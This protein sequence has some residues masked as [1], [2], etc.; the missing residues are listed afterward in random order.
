[1]FSFD[2]FFFFFF[3]RNVHFLHV[4]QIPILFQL[5]RQT[6][7]YERVQE[8]IILWRSDRW[9]IIE[10]MTS[11]TSYCTGGSDLFDG[12]V[13]LRSHENRERII[14]KEFIV[15]FESWLE[16]LNGPIWSEIVPSN[17]NLL[18]LPQTGCNRSY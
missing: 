6:K 10:S 15:R 17:Y 4:K 8:I 16:R 14:A 13:P 5:S 18:G 1:M 2:S 12:R 9:P 7:S 3:I 11:T